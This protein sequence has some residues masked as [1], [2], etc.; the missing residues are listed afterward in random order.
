MTPEDRHTRVW[1]VN[2]DSANLRN[3]R[4]RLVDYVSWGRSHRRSGR[5]H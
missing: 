5:H 2:A 1:D 4:G 3:D